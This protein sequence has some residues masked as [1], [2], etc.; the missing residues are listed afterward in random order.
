MNKATNKLGK[1][2]KDLRK[3]HGETQQ[4]L[5]RAIGVEFNTISM[6]ESGKRQPDL[7]ILQSI[8][9]H[10][11]YTVDQL[12]RAD[13]SDL[14]LSNI[15]FTWEN[16]VSMLGIIFPIVS[17]DKALED[18]CFAKGYAY[19]KKIIADLKKG[20][21][22]MRGL[23]ERALD[24]YSY[25]LKESGTKESAAN[26][27][28]LVYVLYSLL[29]DEHSIKIGKALLYGKAA[30]TE[31]IKNYVL[32]N[33][34]D[35]NE[36]TEMNKKLYA[37]D[38]SEVIVACIQLLKG[39]PEYTNSADY[40]LALRYV[41]GMVDTDYGQDWNKAIGMEMMLSFLTLSNPYAFAFVEKALGMQ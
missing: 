15:V 29:P 37:R 30:R 17:S 2:I 32:K 13:F 26:I 35:A 24:E 27:L 41:I 18:P 10:Y 8:A 20:E 9:S 22:V 5:G 21:A 34:G 4:E 23:F 38:M 33:K 7:Q 19:T 6:Y 40:Y 14:D 31:F 28:W 36:E 25:S 1:N 16:I 3:A 12:I 39:S 11:G